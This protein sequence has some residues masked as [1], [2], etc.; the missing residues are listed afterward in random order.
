MSVTVLSGCGLFRKIH[1]PVR[2]VHFEEDKSREREIEK[3]YREGVDLVERGQYPAAVQSLSGF[4]RRYPSTKYAQEAEF[5]LARAYEGAGDCESAIAHYRAVIT[6]LSSGEALRALAAYRLSFC[7][8][9]LKE[10]VKALAAL[11]DA[12]VRKAHLPREVA[13]AEAPARM[14]TI[15]ARLGNEPLALEHFAEAEKGIEILRRESASPAAF[16]WLPKTFFFMG[17][18]SVGGKEADRSVNS[19]RRAQK[20]LLQAAE[21]GHAEWSGK[22]ADQLIGVYGE[23]WTAIQK[24]HE[25]PPET[26][27]DRELALQRQ[28]QERR[29]LALQVQSSIQDLEDAR[30][31]GEPNEPVG[32]IFSFLRDLNARLTLFLQQTARQDNLTPEAKRRQGVKREGRVRDGNAVLESEKGKAKQ[33]AIKDPNL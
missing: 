16:T 15:Y 20:Y 12:R 24:T 11:R 9:A 25:P 18:M 19:L 28:R 5:H 6:H 10:D 21:S 2:T 4:N 29:D 32:R 30:L 27:E 3:S 8:E 17:Y 26:E 13:L 1:P 31:P 14:A 23:L 33:P 22:A 7:H